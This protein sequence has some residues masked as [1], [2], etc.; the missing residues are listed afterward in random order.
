MRVF[1]TNLGCKLNQ[2][3]L[4]RLARE[5][6][7]AGHR[8]V[9]TLEEAELHVIN[10]CTVTHVA[11]RTS[12]K[13]ARRSK[14]GNPSVHTVLTGCYVASDPEEAA[15]LAGVD[16]VVPN[17]EKHRLVD[18]VHERFPA[19]RPPDSAADE[20]PYGPLEWGN[21]RGLVKIEDGCNV[22]CAFCIIPSTRGRQR[23]RP[24]DEV[25]AEVAGLA[26][27][28]Y[29]EVVLTGVQIS[30]YRW[31][32][33]GLY[34][35]VERILGEARVPRLRLTSLA[36][37]RFDDRILSLV[38]SGRVCRHFHLSLQS[39]AEATLQRMG[40]PY[41]ASG[42]RSLV[43][44]LKAAVPGLAITTDV[45]V[46]FPGEDDSEFEES[47]SFVRDQGFARVHVF[48]YSTRPGTRAA[49]LPE[50]VDHATKR[51]RMD[52]M[53]AVAA[54]AEDAFSRGRVGEEAEVLWEERRDGRWLGTTDHY[55]RVWSDGPGSLGGR[56]GPARL[57]EWTPEGVRAEMVGV[58]RRSPAA[59][60]KPRVA[61]RQSG[62]R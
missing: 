17:E 29:Q 19:L 2:A 10:T 23:S 36:P 3:E 42:Y 35:L 55:L 13:E 49:E 45:I 58:S 53:L 54:S 38:H 20:L 16:L 25:V 47:L 50:T 30:H 28:G 61:G 51:E 52:R 60:Q 24:D 41:R 6:T 43:S 57:A 7:A 39:G 15:T 62:G 9:G 26:R 56:L 1:F 46:G 5:M 27:E 31:E 21:T 18:R 37:W 48:P 32:G 59:G 12:R 14:R 34:E 4:E 11:A 40:R 33:R 22:N 8:V 44:R